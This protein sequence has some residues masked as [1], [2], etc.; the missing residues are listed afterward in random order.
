MGKLTLVAGYSVEARATFIG[1]AGDHFV[2]RSTMRGRP[3]L[4]F[5]RK[6]GG[7]AGYH[8]TAYKTRT[9]ALEGWPRSRQYRGSL[10]DYG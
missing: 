5:L 4:R 2:A 8:V 3:W 6:L 1:N 7:A 9:L 10:V